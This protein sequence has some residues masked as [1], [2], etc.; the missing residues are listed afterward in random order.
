M[1]PLLAVAAVCV[2]AL[3]A[4]GLCRAARLTGEVI[5]STGHLRREGL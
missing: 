3:V 5:A 1:R 2:T 4:C